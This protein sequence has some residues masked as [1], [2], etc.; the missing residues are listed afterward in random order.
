MQDAQDVTRMQSA[1]DASPLATM[2]PTLGVR[3]LHEARLHPVRPGLQTFFKLSRAMRSKLEQTA[4][5][6][7]GDARRP[8]GLVEI[9]ANVEQQNDKLNPAPLV[10]T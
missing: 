7:T 8:P 1:S 5:R 2:G 6:W 10:F 4:W 9:P 3:A